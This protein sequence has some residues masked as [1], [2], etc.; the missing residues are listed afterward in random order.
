MIFAFPAIYTIFH[1][2]SEICKYGAPLYLDYKG[3]F[4]NSGFGF[5]EKMNTFMITRKKCR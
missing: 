5:I 4:T 1:Q 3:D 2:S